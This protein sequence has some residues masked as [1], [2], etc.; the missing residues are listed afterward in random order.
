[1]PGN[2][3]TFTISVIC[4]TDIEIQIALTK[5]N[6]VLASIGEISGARHFRCR[7]RICINTR[8]QNE[9]KNADQCE[10]S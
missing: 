2:P 10:V 7:S 6:A 4:F 3:Q 5:R 8:A 9:Q 1:M